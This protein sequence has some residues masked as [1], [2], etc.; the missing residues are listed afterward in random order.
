[1]TKT[2]TSPQWTDREISGYAWNL[3]KRQARMFHGW[4]DVDDLMQEFAVSFVQ[5][6]RLV[7]E[8]RG[9]AAFMAMWKQRVAWRLID[10]KRAYL[11]G[12]PVP[13][14]DVT[15]DPDEL[16][17]YMA[18]Y[19]MEWEHDASDVLERALQ[20]APQ[21]VSAWVHAVVKHGHGGVNKAGETLEKTVRRVTGYARSTVFQKVKLWAE[22]RLFP[23]LSEASSVIV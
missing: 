6:T 9:P 16:L 13:F 12:Q 22:D 21:E 23:L 18:Q 19:V 8:S 15:E 5:V 14:S 4:I 17:S 2:M 10:L 7:D 20:G 3:A 11:K 1:M